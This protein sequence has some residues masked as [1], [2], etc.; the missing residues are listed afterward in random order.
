MYVIV[1][2][3]GVLGF[4]VV[5]ALVG[6]GHDVVVVDIDEASCERSYAELGATAIHGSATDIHLLE[7]AGA[8]RAD[9]VIAMMHRD[10][11]N[12]ACALLARTLGVGRVIARMRDTGYEDSYRAAGVTHVVRATAVLRNQILAHIEHPRVSE[13]M[14]VRGERVQIFAL[15][16]PRG[17]AVAG[18]SVREVAL[19]RGFPAKSLLL[20]AI[21][22]SGELEILRGDG[23]LAA[24]DTILAMADAADIER[25]TDV[26]TR[27]S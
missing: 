12:V 21:T 24:G 7:E 1:A 5:R 20:A 16:I 27:P 14:S 17:A 4:E 19:H 10:S 11:D 22:P 26:L 18:R 9:V 6:R 15:E 13:L 8:R 3:A 2:G 25:L 23:C